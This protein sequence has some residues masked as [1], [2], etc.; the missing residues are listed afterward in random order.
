MVPMDED[1]PALAG[2]AAQAVDVLN[3]ATSASVAYPGLTGL[4][5]T[6]A[7]LVS[8]T[9]LADELQQ[10]ASHLGDYLLDQRAKGVLSTAGGSRQTVDAA[11]D[12]A[13][14]VLEQVHGA[15]GELSSLL[16]DAELALLALQSDPAR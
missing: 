2:V 5:D 6:E 16:T 9:R 10:T 15:A 7:V 14:R 3:D 8:L 12:R 1:A 11:V 4:A 13:R